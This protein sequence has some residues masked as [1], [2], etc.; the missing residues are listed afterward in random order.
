MALTIDQLQIQIEA[1]SSKASS[2]IDALIGR[3]ENLQEKL[4]GLGNAGKNASNGLKETAKGAEKASVATDKHS[5]SNNNAT[6]STKKFTDKLANQ[7][8]KYRTL[9]GAFKS[10][11]NMMA[12]WFN[13][14]N[15]YIET[16]NLFNVTMGD[17]AAEATNFANKVS[18]LMG[19]D[20][21][22][23]MQYQG[24]FKQ[25]ASGFGVS[26]EQANLMSQNLTQL[27]YDMGSF[28]NSDTEE[29]FDKLSS[30]MAGQVKGLRDYGID[31]TV[32]SLQEYALSKGIETKVRAMTQAEKSLLR[33][34]YIMEKSVNIQGD[35]ARTIITPANSMRIL[36]AQM[37]KFKRALGDVVSVLIVQFIPYV[38]AMVEILTEAA[39]AL[40]QF[41][42][43]DANDFKADVSGIAGSFSGGFED[44]AESA[45]GVSDSVKKIKKQMMGFDELNILSSPDSDSDTSGSAAVGGGGLGG[46]E[47]AEYDFLKGLEVKNLDEIKDKL[48]DIFK[49]V[50]IVGGAFATWKFM[51]GF[52][53]GI[54]ALTGLFGK[55][56]KS[57]GG[58]SK[59]QMPSAKVVLKGLG[60]LGIIIGGVMTLAVTMG[61]LMKIPGFEETIIEGMQ[62]LGIAF[63]GI[64]QIAAPLTAVSVA[65]VLLGKIGVGTIA[66]GFANFAIII[67]GVP[68]LLTAVGALMSIPYF[69]TFLSTGIESVKAVFNGLYDVAIPIGLLS[70]L[71]IALGIATPYVIL[72][73]F[74]GFA[75]IVGGTTVL[76]TA[77][78]ALLSIPEFG[79]F[80]S[81]GISSVQEV[82]NGLYDIAIPIA[83]LSALLIGL[84]IA[85]PAV[86]L[87][88]ITGFAIVVGGLEVLLVALGALSQ[89]D[90]FTWIVG[91][92]GKLLMQL[93][94]IIGGFAGSLIGGF[95]EGIS[96]SFPKIGADLA[97]FMENAKPFFDGLNSVD[98]SSA[99]A[100]KHLAG[101]ILTLTAANVLEGLTSWFAGESSL[102]DFGA[103][104][105]E[106]GPHFKKYADSIKGV[107]GEAVKS[108]S[109]AA[110]AVCEFAK[111]IPNSGGVAGW[112]AGENDIDVFGKKLPSFG[113]NF[114]QYADSIKG[115]DKSVVENSANAAK[116]VIE[117]AKEIPNSGGVAAWFAGNNDIDT[118]GAKLPEFGKN[119]KK[120]HDNIKGIDKSVIEA[121][122]TAA[123]SVVEIAKNIPN[124]GGVV[125]WFTGDNGIDKF[126]AKLPQFGKDFKAYYDSIK[127]IA[128]STLN[129]VTTG[130][131]NLVN[132]AKKVKT[133]V[134]S[135]AIDKFAKS[136]RNLADN[137]AKLPTQKNIGL[138]VTYDTWV[139]TDKE[140]VY[141]ALGLSG[142]PSMK[143]YAYAS[144]GL[145]SVG[146]MFI[147]REAGPELVG[148]IGRK[149]AVAN[150]DQIVSGIESGV[151][152]AVVAA[153]STKQGGTQTIRIINEIDGDVVGEKVIQYHNGKVIQTGVSPLL[154]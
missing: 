7:I 48:K 79:N 85:T 64:A 122:S 139:S 131:N 91:E 58:G 34:N 126:G 11:A 101:A 35:M 17:G 105:E 60:N 19:I 24:T 15:D 43:F 71:M 154:V 14:S 32:A 78:G 141:K 16:L 5:K 69:G 121:S 77:I 127:G 54:N 12:G 22:E 65:C 26:A 25:L 83:A 148:N 27:S 84:G 97:G 89:I 33:Y 124:S 87:S 3:L 57:G 56:S 132:F 104:L 144:G 128:A 142:W 115:I 118:F 88:G 29:A 116:A 13:E 113:K 134:D 153:N 114:K 9:M 137:M 45:E 63:K 143:W 108:S 98:A 47:L 74:A 23:W 140:K 138:S 49:W 75:L 93:G 46:M 1:E 86:I 94:N 80:L 36:E 21:G 95:A 50:G 130:L 103:D 2:A 70:V 67:A 76:L 51:T 30:A 44:A 53:T 8:S 100:V 92:G 111:N 66:K 38:Q 20:P 99:E 10:A 62:S 82:F 152:R 28:F 120:Y 150:N 112:F 52:A 149:S 135:N 59:F 102:A 31:V 18:D 73:G 4:N 68:V 55:G 110:K 42:G 90:G 6:K 72:S 145:P 123:K 133:D 96:A 37:T 107:D 146:E 109:I 119:F 151:Y 40:A 136:L 129:S 41:F 61:L 106:F 81:T 125:S 147:A 117:I 39:S